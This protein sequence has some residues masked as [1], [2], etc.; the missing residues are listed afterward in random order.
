MLTLRRFDPTMCLP[1]WSDAAHTRL[2]AFIRLC[3]REVYSNRRRSVEESVFVY[4]K[5]GLRSTHIQMGGCALFHESGIIFVTAMV[6]AIS[7]TES[8]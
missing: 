4:T 5:A 8:R 3:T 2:D 6:R 7:G 1:L